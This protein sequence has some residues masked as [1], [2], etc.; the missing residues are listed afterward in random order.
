MRLEILQEL[1][2]IRSVSRHECNILNYVREVIS[3]GRI[4]SFEQNT[5]YLYVK[6]KTSAQEKICYIIHVDEVGFEFGNVITSHIRELQLVGFIPKCSYWFTDVR[7]ENNNYI[8]CI[9][10]RD[11]A[12]LY[13]GYDDDLVL[14]FP[15]SEHMYLAK[16]NTPLN[17]FNPLNVFKDTI[18]GKGLDNKIGMAA[19]LF[20]I[21]EIFDSNASVLFT[22][23]EELGMINYPDAI[24]EVPVL[25]VIDAY[26]TTERDCILYKGPII[27]GDDDTI[28]NFIPFVEDSGLRFQ[29]TTHDKKTGTEID[30]I[31]SDSRYKNN[32]FLMLLYPLS[33]M[34][35]PKEIASKSDCDEL[36]KSVKLS[37]DYFK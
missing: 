34:H 12:S 36:I 5:D 13:N 31:I 14:Y 9:M 24:F 37:M 21:D 28:N 16:K 4:L 27:D 22:T 32:S 7:D 30:F 1:L 18:I 29:R 11:E 15:N 10:P 26:T 17:L 3:A 25:V 19:I 23:K 35:T 2:N 6:N 33:N 8:G 20:L